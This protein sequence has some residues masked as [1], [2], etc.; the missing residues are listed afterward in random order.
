MCFSGKWY[1]VEM[2][3]S[4]PKDTS[5]AE[6]SV[7]G[8]DVQTVVDATSLDAIYE[9]LVIETGN[10]RSDRA[11]NLGRVNTIILPALVLYFGIGAAQSIAQNWDY[12]IFI[13]IIPFFA[14]IGLLIAWLTDTN[15]YQEYQA[16]VERGRQ[17][18]SEWKQVG[19]FTLTDIS[20][21]GLLGITHS[22]RLLLLYGVA[23][24]FIAIFQFSTLSAP[25]I[26]FLKF[27]ILF[28]R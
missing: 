6:I 20:T 12:N 26:S 7:K 14:L 21:T 5:S 22:Q 17:I 1:K 2:A 10:L 3:Q 23:W 24:A 25:L 11:E 28:V 15:M 8:S 4:G 9:G 19:G 13:R 16:K 27:V 18:E